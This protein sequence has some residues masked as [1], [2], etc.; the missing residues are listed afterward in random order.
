MAFTNE[1]LNAM[2]SLYRALERTSL[3]AAGAGMLLASTAA[4]APVS[5][6]ADETATTTAAMASSTPL[7]D[8]TRPTLAFSFAGTITDPTAMNPIPVRAHFSEPVTGFTAASLNIGLGTATD[9]MQIS[10]SDYS[11]NVTIGAPEGSVSIDSNDPNVKDAA[12]NIAIAAPQLNVRYDSHLSAGGTGGTTGTTGTTTATSTGSTGDT[13][14]GGTGTGGTGSG[15][16]TSSWISFISGPENGSTISTSTATFVFTTTGVT[17]LMCSF[18]AVTAAYGCGSPQ[19]FSGLVNGFYPFTVSADYQGSATSTT[20]SFTVD[21][22][23]ASTTAAST[24]SPGTATTTDSS[25]TSASG[26]SNIGPVLGL[27]SGHSISGGNMYTLAAT[28]FS[29]GS[30][31]SGTTTSTTNTVSGGTRTSTH[32]A[33]SGAVAIVPYGSAAG[34]TVTPVP[35]TASDTTALPIAP[36]SQEAAAGLSG[37]SP[38]IL[39]GLG[40]LLLAILGTLL[41]WN[42]RRTQ[43]N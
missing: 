27:T 21:L 16:A 20:R 43:T 22:N 25:S 9:F 33:G 36:S 42:H 35:L 7:A 23:A 28:G 1:F 34:D 17:N 40:L 39:W 13:G 12:G 18:G 15:T 29:G 32:V 4:F 19:T 24:T 10:P 11:F 31:G 8:T 3:I 41:Y 37:I 38:A 2:K 6:F 5:A 26:S 30:S 14:T